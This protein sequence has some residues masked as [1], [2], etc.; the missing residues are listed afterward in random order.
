MFKTVSFHPWQKSLFLHSPVKAKEKRPLLAGKERG[1]FAIP[2]AKRW[3]TFQSARITMSMIR[4]TCR[5][6]VAAVIRAFPFYQ[7]IPGSILD[8][9]VVCGLSFQFPLFTKNQY[10]NLISLNF[11]WSDLQSYF[12]LLVKHFINDD[13]NNS[14]KS[15]HWHKVL[16]KA[17]S[18]CF[19]G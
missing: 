4:L 16:V 14:T 12:N 8:F 15:Y 9:C 3:L 17:L 18:T 10:F 1:S 7:C 19:I 2:S 6:R 13:D 5:S 11:T